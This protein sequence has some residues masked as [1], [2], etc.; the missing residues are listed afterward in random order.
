VDEW[1]KGEEARKVWN[2]ARREEWEKEVQ[3]WKEL[4]K[5]RGKRPLLGNLKKAEPK[6][7][8][9]ANVVADDDDE[10]SV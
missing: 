4:P 7:S 8:H 3:A 6:P 5:P 10:V 2:V 1:K 9:P